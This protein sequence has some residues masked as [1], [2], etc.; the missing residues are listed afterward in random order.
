M[1]LF[2]VA[3]NE[4]LDSDDQ[5]EPRKQTRKELLAAASGTNVKT[6]E[7]NTKAIISGLAEMFGLIGVTEKDLEEDIHLRHYL[8]YL[9]FGENP[10]PYVLLEKDE[11]EERKD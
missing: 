11:P 6:V 2:I 7:R 9:L 5:G 4:A 3:D 1:R 10:E 8:R